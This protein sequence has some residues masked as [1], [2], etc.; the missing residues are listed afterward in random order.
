MKRAIILFLFLVTLFP[1]VSALDIN[2]NSNVSK[3][4]TIIASL[5]GNFLDPVI[6]DN[7]YFYRGH[8]RTSFDYDV[9]KIG[10]I[11]YIYVL[12]ANKAENNYS[13]NISGVR[14]MVG[15]QLSTEQISKSFAITNKTADFSVNPGFIITNGNFS[16]KIQNLQSF[17]ITINIE[18]EIN[19][20]SASGI[21]EFTFKGEKAGQSIN[22]SPGELRDLY[23]G[24]KDISGI[25]IRTITLSANNTEYKILSYL[26]LGNVSVPLLN[27]TNATNYNQTNNTNTTECSFFGKLFGTCDTN[28]VQNETQENETFTNETNETSNN[29]PNADYEVIKVG[30]RTFVVKDGEVLNESATLK[31]C[32]QINGDV[33]SSEEICRNATIYAKDA[34]CC[35]SKCVKQEEKTNSRYIGWIMLGIL[36]LI[37][38]WFFI[39]RYGGTKNKK[40]VL[41]SPKK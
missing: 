17:P 12:T 16:I 29:A 7:I 40:D 9:A 27:E 21:F 5:S 14:Y 24:I 25:T 4:E 34:K 8:V 23:V 37:V 39:K 41:L 2:M 13:I 11:Y 6:K 26:I 30:N 19:S 22:L 38:L 3:G 31:T 10:D 18:T 33:C 1:I 32:A 28:S 35:I 20:G 15:S 36:V